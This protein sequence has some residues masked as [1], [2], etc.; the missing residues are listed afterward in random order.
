MATQGNTLFSILG[1]TQAG[2]V[3]LELGAAAAAQG[4]QPGTVSGFARWDIQQL[5]ALKDSGFISD[6]AYGILAS[7]VN[8]ETF[9]KLATD[10][11]I[12]ENGWLSLLASVPNRPLYPGSGGA[13]V[14]YR[15]EFSCPAVT[16]TY[17]DATSVTQVVPVSSVSVTV[18]DSR[19]LVGY[20]SVPTVKLGVTLAAGIKDV[21]FRTQCTEVAGAA[22]GKRQYTVKTDLIVAI[23][24]SGSIAAGDLTG[25]G[26]ASSYPTTGFAIKK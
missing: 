5:T 13:T 11:D 12:T 3:G 21:R 16:L 22:S 19:R 2:T 9:S 20:E 15:E 7:G 25:I 24:A 10:G 17:T 6:T 18:P 23:S 26:L 1:S 4:S 14:V 8:F